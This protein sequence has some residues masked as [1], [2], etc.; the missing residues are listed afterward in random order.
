MKLFI[1]L[2]E[3]CY[4]ETLNDFILC[5]H[6]TFFYHYSMRYSVKIHRLFSTFFFPHCCLFIK[7]DFEHKTQKLASA[8]Q[9]YSYY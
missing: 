4:Y 3:K 6:I 7:L 8:W 1:G 9:T 2:F 5:F